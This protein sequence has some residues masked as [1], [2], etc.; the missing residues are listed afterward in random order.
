MKHLLSLPPNLIKS[1][2]QVAGVDPAQW[3]CTS[4]PVGARLGSGG[5]TTW[6][7]QSCYEAESQGEDFAQ[8]LAHEKRVLL[9]AGGQGR[10]IPAYAPSGKVLTPIPVFRAGRGQKLDQTLLDLQMPL[11]ERILRSAPQDIHTIIVSGDVMIKT[12]DTTPLPQA[13]VI[14]FG[15]WED[16]S[17]ASHHGVFMIKRD[18][19]DRLDFM[20]QKP[21][22][23]TL[24]TL[25]QTHYFLM[26]VG[27]WLLSDKAIERLRRLTLTP[28]GQILN[29]DLYSNFGTGLGF[30][31]S[32]PEPL[33]QDLTVSIVPLPN[34]EFY[35]YGTSRELLSSTTGQMNSVKDQRLIIHNA[36]KQHPSIFTQNAVVRTSVDLNKPNIW[37]ENS[38][39]PH[40]WSLASRSIITGVPVNNWTIN[41]ND[42]QCVDIVPI[43]DKDYALR[44]YGFDDTFRGALDDPETTFLG[45][46]VG[47]WL[48]DRGITLD[49]FSNTTDIQL[50]ELFPVSP[51]TDTIGRWLEWFIS[52]TPDKKLTQSWRNARRISADSITDTA[53]LL[54]L[55]RQRQSYRAENIPALADNYARS[56]FYQLDLADLAEKYSKYNLELPKPLPDETP[57]MTRIHDAM[58]RSRVATLKGTDDGS[59]WSD[60]AFRML[61]EG[62]VSNAHNT[63]N[64][65]RLDVCH[66]QIVW[67][68]S[69][70]R[71]DVAGGWTDTPPYSLYTGG[72]VVNLA[73]NLNGQPPLQVYV[74]PNKNFNIVCRSIDL[75]AQEIIETYE[76]LAEFS[77]V[78]SPFS[79][80]KAA[81]ALMGFLP[82]YSPDG[83]TSLRK[84]LEDFGAGID[85]TLMAA[86]PA[87]SGLGTSSILAATVLGALSDF[88]GLGLSRRDICARTL[89]LEQ[90]LTTGGGWQDQY[91]GALPGIKM[92]SS[93]PGFDQTVSA[94]YLPDTIFRN[95]AGACH[96]LYYTGIT[97]TAKHIL[98]DIVKGM[99]LNESAR[100][101][102]LSDMKHH[103]HEMQQ[104][105]QRG[106]LRNYGRLLRRS[107]ELNCQL[108]PDTAPETVKQLCKTIDDLCAGY[109][110]PGAGGG[111]YMY[112]VAKD[113]EAAVALRTLL[114]NNP[115]TPTARWVDMSL[116]DNGLQVS[117]S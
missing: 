41:L 95:E 30:T 80:P 1:F 31:P 69:S 82:A 24:A 85:I 29:Y 67:A 46:P 91:G 89:L 77:K 43:G 88:C 54:R 61:Q 99:F 15:L 86:I 59:R 96:L 47:K 42:G 111:G 56:I 45:V 34:G 113:P 93:E 4:D 28:D 70:A 84:Q 11:Y 57:T 103:A 97:R 81:L 16:P 6:L 44:P 32:Q 10:R 14:C 106:D 18:Q 115:I 38:F 49:D 117:R 39:V 13:D 51:D 20:L 27:I 23:A 76:Q 9:H 109:K 110:L 108:D 104:A 75:G 2:H 98:D 102:I 40:T 66:D 112:M 55:D 3:Y 92:L 73:I 25:A 65:P 26:D 50:A 33:L 114:N 100:L 107:W 52:P 79:I 64:A 7:L 35:H 21:T 12:T 37:I 83:F 78:G 53:N 60:K 116:S 62:I 36:I 90:L 8:W 87:G 22:T 58:F 48:D 71:I 17:L 68:R 5:G 105:I 63:N 19:P 94:D 72:N 101:S 74:K